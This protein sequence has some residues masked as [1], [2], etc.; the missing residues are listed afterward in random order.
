MVCFE[1]LGAGGAVISAF[2]S[3]KS[4]PKSYLLPSEPGI[5]CS[6]V[7]PSKAMFSFWIL[8]LLG[9]VH[10]GLTAVL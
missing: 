8:G 2:T 9:G 3:F 4:G 1:R 5:S 6:D 7:V 10:G